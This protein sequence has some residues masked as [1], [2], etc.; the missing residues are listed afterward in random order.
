MTGYDVHIVGSVPL[1]SAAA[2]FTAV[3]AALGDRISTI[4][5]GETG[6]RLTW[7]G[8]LESV[9][10]DNPALELA[11]QEFRVHPNAPPQKQYRL[12]PG[13]TASA[14]HF[15]DLGYAEIAARSY[16]DF[17]AA[18]KAGK[19]PTLCRFQVDIA[20]AHTVVRSFI[21]E[22]GQAAVEPIYDA[23]LRSE[24]TKICDVVP[25]DELAI[26]LDIASSVFYRLEKGEPTRYGATKAEMQE[27]FAR[28]AIDLGAC[29]P[30]NVELI[31]H[32]CYGDSNHRH[33]IEPSSTA[34]MVEFANRISRGIGRPIRLF[35]MPVPR[36]R[37]D[38][39]YFEPLAGL[40]L[41]PETRLCLG[42]VHLTDG[43]AGTRNRIA[44]AEKY[45]T[46]FLIATECGFGRRPPDTVAGLL[47]IHADVA[48]GP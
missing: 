10:T 42:L 35:H 34:D 29:V 7:I 30:E 20:P 13:V 44:S 17:A 36:E 22:D 46:G 2:V 8:W 19:I 45:V 48:N 9:F 15:G 23:A 26:Q 3:G 11:G 40:R 24:I 37:T 5:D 27:A 38:D 12:K 31:Y 4:P 21:H 32:L 28:H 14:L 25:R 39:G 16:R 47:R 33:S 18:K 1:D 43:V 41:R 6:E